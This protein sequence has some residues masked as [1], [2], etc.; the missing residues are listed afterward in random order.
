M[1]E[2]EARM[3]PNGCGELSYAS[4]RINDNEGRT[5]WNVSIPYCPE[6]MYYEDGETSL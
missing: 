4:G 1:N 2:N 3:C 6:C 5:Y